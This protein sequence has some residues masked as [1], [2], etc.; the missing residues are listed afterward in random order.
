MTSTPKPGGHTPGPWKS[1][2]IPAGYATGDGQI[3]IQGGE[4]RLTLVAHIPTERDAPRGMRQ[5][6][7][8]ARLIA[9]APQLL[10][11]LKACVRKLDGIKMS[12]RHSGDIEIA[13]CAAR[14]EQAARAI[15]V[16]AEA[17]P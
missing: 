4:D 11:A 8:N 15:I 9:A 5:R 13:E 14:A 3:E 1:V 6:K 12:L 10:E 17:H 7:A 2:H 16:Q